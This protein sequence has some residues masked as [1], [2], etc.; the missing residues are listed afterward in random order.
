MSEKGHELELD[1]DQREEVR[2]M[3]EKFGAKKKK[4]AS[5][6]Q[7]QKKDQQ[8]ADPDPLE[9]SPPGSTIEWHQLTPKTRRYQFVRES[10]AL[11]VP[12]ILDN[13]VLTREKLDAMIYSTGMDVTSQ[14][15]SLTVCAIDQAD[16]I[17]V[18]QI[19]T[20]PDDQGILIKT[21]RYIV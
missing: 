13:I 12:Y 10:R 2:K 20:V 4:Q 5:Q 18:F 16:P 11:F 6:Q 7:A 14:N 1:D 17:R 8:R 21:I 15:A 9:S 19:Q 3:L